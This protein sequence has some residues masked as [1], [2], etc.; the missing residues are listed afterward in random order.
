MPNN[1]RSIDTPWEHS[2]IIYIGTGPDCVAFDLTI[3]GQKCVGMFYFDDKTRSVINYFESIGFSGEVVAKG[4]NVLCIYKLLN[5]GLHCLTGPAVERQLAGISEYSW[6]K[7]GKPWYC[8]LN[9]DGT[10]YQEAEGL[11]FLHGCKLSNTIGWRDW[12][13][14]NGE[15]WDNTDVF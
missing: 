7:R 10:R 9:R 14:F 4:E 13:W 15:L 5:G 11:C 12:A 6:W 3:N 1:Y 8:L 2:E